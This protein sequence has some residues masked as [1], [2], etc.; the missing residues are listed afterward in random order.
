MALLK[1]PSRCSRIDNPPLESRLTG[2][3]LPG[4]RHLPARLATTARSAHRARADTTRIG[5]KSPLDTPAGLV[6]M[7]LE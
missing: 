4:D 6:I 1:V 7:G 3:P 5:K 2:W